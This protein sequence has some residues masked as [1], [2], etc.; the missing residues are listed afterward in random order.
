MS[1]LS[2]AWE[3]VTL[4][5]EQLSYAADDVYAP[6]MSYE[7]LSKLTVLKPLPSEP[8]PMTP[9]LLY[10]TDNTVLIASGHVSSHFNGEDIN[11]VKIGW[12]HTGVNISKVYVPAAII[13]SH[14]KQALKSFGPPPFSVVCLRSH[15]CVYDP[16][17]SHLLTT[18]SDAI[19]GQPTDVDIVMEPVTA[20]NIG[21]VSNG[22][23][24][25]MAGD[26]DDLK[27]SEGVGHL[28][29][30]A[31]NMIG[32]TELETDVISSSKEVDHNSQAFGQQIFSTLR[33]S[34]T[35]DDTLQSHVL[36]DVFH[37]FNMLCLSTSHSLRK[38]FGWA[39]H[40]AIFVPDLEDPMQIL[41]WASH[42]KPPKTFE[43]LQMKQPA[44]LWKRC[45]RVIPPPDV[46]FPLIEQLFA[47]YGPLKD[48]S[49]NVPLFNHYNWKT[50][51]SILELIHQGYVSDPP[52]ISL[53]TVIG[54]DSKAGNLPIYHCSRGTNFTEGSVHTHLL[55]YLP[56]SGVS[57]HHL[58]ARLCDFVLQ[59]N[60]RV[61]FYSCIP[62]T[63]MLM[64]F[65]SRWECSTALAR[66]I[67][68]TSQ[69]GLQTSFK[70]DFFFSG[71]F[72]FISL[73]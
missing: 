61:C 11:G 56:L 39:L 65:L 37:V 70:S 24:D 68:A 6:L 42:L 43:N 28:L 49:T 73:R 21:I 2:A 38:E 47:T 18:N 31:P 9:V 36:K 60:L 27:P 20:P 1:F 10:N 44:W 55:S 46:L 41:A 19:N 69:Y 30:D 33:N 32:S 45:R 26:D 71:T 58:N 67:A 17:S 51:W 3:N 23:G 8:I 63:L 22:D 34:E 14:H 59:H 57:V 53:Y 4:S 12:I 54:L 7:K 66:S 35:W 15:L 52:G 62:W 25:S 64:H 13:S 16:L 50:A 40:D 48:S 72:L 5:S 29:H